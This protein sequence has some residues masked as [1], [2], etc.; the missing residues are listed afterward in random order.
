MRDARHI[1]AFGDVVDNIN[2]SVVAHTN[3][4][5]PIAT[6]EFLTTGGSGNRREISETRHDPGYHLCRQPVQFSF[7]T[8]S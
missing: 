6:L 2:N 5:F 7:R 1:H 4:P 8:C 3:A